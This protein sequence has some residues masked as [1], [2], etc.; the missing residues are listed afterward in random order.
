LTT[1][2]VDSIHNL[3]GTILGSSRGGFNLK[4]IAKAL[5]KKGIN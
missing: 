1:D 2:N 3:G 4:E 5:V